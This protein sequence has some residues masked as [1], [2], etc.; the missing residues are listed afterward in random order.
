M[1]RMLFL[2]I[3]VF[4]SKYCLDVSCLLSPFYLAGN[5][6]VRFDAKIKV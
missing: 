5:F 6:L 3:W 2:I 1:F 4:I